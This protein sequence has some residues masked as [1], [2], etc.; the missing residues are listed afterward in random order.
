ML[1]RLLMVFFILS[2]ISFGQPKF[3]KIINQNHVESLTPVHAWGVTTIK[4]RKVPNL[5]LPWGISQSNVNDKLQEAIEMWGAPNKYTFNLVES[6]DLTGV[7]V[8]FVSDKTLFKNYRTDAAISTMA[9]QNDGQ[10][11]VSVDPSQKIS[12][13]TTTFIA[14]NNCDGFTYKDNWTTFYPWSGEISVKLALAHEIGHTFG[15]MH[16]DSMQED[17][18]E[19]ILRTGLDISWLS[20]DDNSGLSQLYSCTVNGTYTGIEDG[21]QIHPNAPTEIAS[22]TSYSFYYSFIDNAPEGN[23]LTSVSFKLAAFH[24]GGEYT[25]STS[26]MG[27]L[28][29]F[30][31]T[32]SWSTDNLGRVKGYFK[33]TGTD[34][35]GVIHESFKEVYFKDIYPLPLSATVSGP[36]SL[37]QSEN[38]TYT[39]NGSNGNP[40]YSY[41]WEIYKLSITKAL[42]SDKWFNIG[43][44]SATYTKVVPSNGDYR[45]FKL[46]CTIADASGT[47]V[48]SNEKYVSY[49]GALAKMSNEST[50]NSFDIMETPI[51]NNIGNH[52]NPF[53]PS[54]NIEYSIAEN[55]NVKII[56]FNVLG[57]QIA[58]LVNTE[59]TPGHYTVKFDATHLPS[60]MYYCRI[61]AGNFNK[62]I[63]MLLTK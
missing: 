7:E 29:Y 46:R 63:K 21:I 47:K 40:P 51:K 8:R 23:Y 19:P 43:T 10:I 60:G 45:D 25:V 36:S 5:D 33:V 22:N 28:P 59:K 39:C 14:L 44:N 13:G 27:T 37:G 42:P 9:V 26:N 32:Y 18:M 56:V 61:V 57:E 35:V 34:N 41:Q 4:Y 6:W 17:V 2:T 58:E 16:Y 53:N 48:T 31:N 15:L 20:S 1:Y 30:P 24:S 52:P 11:K 62:T 54:T 49:M 12:K 55:S 38:G 3:L 50:N